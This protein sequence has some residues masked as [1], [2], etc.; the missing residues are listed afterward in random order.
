MLTDRNAKHDAL[1]ETGLTS[2]AGVSTCLSC[3]NK[4]DVFAIEAMEY[5]RG[6]KGN[7]YESWEYYQL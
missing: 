1:T 7:K 3:T 5:I 2:G 6:S 4:A